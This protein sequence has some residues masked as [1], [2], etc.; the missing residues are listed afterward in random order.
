[1]QCLKPGKKRI[2]PLNRKT[3]RRNQREVQNNANKRSSVLEEIPREDWS[4]H[5][6]GTTNC[7]DQVYLSKYFLVQIYREKGI[8]DRISVCRNEIDKKGMFTDGITW[9]ELQEIKNSVGYSEWDCVEIF[10]AE[11]DVVNIANFRHLWALG[12]LGFTWRK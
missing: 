4:C 11:K 5:A 1:M 10:P 8:P 9:E 6:S 7:L 2:K 3:R 12:K